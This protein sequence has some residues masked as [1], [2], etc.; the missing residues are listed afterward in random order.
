MLPSTGMGRLDGRVA[1]VTGAGRGLGRAI[2]L[3]CG[4]EGADLAVSYNA[5]GPAAKD[6]VAELERLGRRAEAVQADVAHADQV[7]AMLAINVTGTLLCT[8]HALR[9]TVAARYERIIN[10]STQ[11]LRASVGT[12]GFTAYAATKG[13]IES[14]TRALADGPGAPAQRRLGH[15]VSRKV[16]DA[17]PERSAVARVDRVRAA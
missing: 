16:T 14:F 2:A 10:F 11:F 3:T 12:G 8:Q 7:R 6:V 17:V 15:G 13:A 5:S 1:L 4:R 9:P